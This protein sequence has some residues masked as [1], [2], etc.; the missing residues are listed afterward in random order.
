MN[1]PACGVAVAADAT[2]CHRCG[3]RVVDLEGAGDA[4]TDT[5][6]GVEDLKQRV[7]AARAS[8]DVEEEL[9]SGGYSPKAMFGSWIG[10]TLLT[11]ALIAGAVLIPPIMLGAIVAI[12][13]LWILLA[14]IYLYRRLGI[15][16]RL[17]SQRFFHEKGILRRVTNRIECIDMDDI[18]FE[19][20]PIE[21]M[22]GIG[23]IRII[24]SDASDPVLTLSGIDN[25]TEVAGKIDNARRQ[26]RRRRGLH[27]EAV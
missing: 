14:F 9:W 27:I 3:A 8:S 18:A 19:Q 24:S 20:G 23:T 11:V 10:A 13:V 26:E 17:T 16:Y 25:L 7:Q 15:H 2:F 22:L 1:C 12:P 5:P 21:R 6:G 4:R